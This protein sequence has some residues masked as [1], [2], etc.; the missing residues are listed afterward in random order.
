MSMEECDSAQIGERGDEIVHQLVGTIYDGFDQ[1]W[2]LLENFAEN[3]TSVYRRRIE[4]THEDPRWTLVRPRTSWDFIDFG[5]IDPVPPLFDQDVDKENQIIDDLLNCFLGFHGRYINAESL[6]NP[7]GD[8]IFKI[9]DTVT[10]ICR[11]MAMRLLPLASYYSKIVRF[12]QKGL[13]LSTGRVN[14]ALSGYLEE[15]ILKFSEMIVLLEERHSK[16]PLDLNQL[17]FCLQGTTASMKV[18][19]DVVCAVQDLRG[20]ATLTALHNFCNTCIIDS[21]SKKL[22]VDATLAASEPYFQSI[23]MWIYKGI[24]FDPF[25]EFMVTQKVSVKGPTNW[26]SMFN[27]RV[28]EVPIFLVDCQTYIYK[29]GKYLDAVR[30]SLD[31]MEKMPLLSEE[32]LAY[33]VADE[34][35][36]DIIK[37][38][39]CFASV[40]LLDLMLNRFNLFERIKTTKSFLCLEGGDL[41]HNIIDNCGEELDRPAHEVCVSYLP[42]LVSSSV[43]TSSLGGLKFADQMVL[44]LEKETLRWQVYNL[45]PYGGND[46]ECLEEQTGLEALTFKMEAKWPVSLV[47]H[48]MSIKCYQM[49]FRHLFYLKRIHFKLVRTRQN[50]FLSIRQQYLRHI[51]TVFLQYCISYM[52]IGTIEVHWLD[53]QLA[54]NEAGSVEEVRQAHD[55]M[56]YKCLQGCM[57]ASPKLFHKLRNVLEICSNFADDLCLK[58]ENPFITAVSRLINAALLEGPSAGLENFTKEIAPIFQYEPRIALT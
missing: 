27:I 53:F 33:D 28:S 20:G 8:R 6:E 48:Q 44:Y 2:K 54:F 11:S 37:R 15:K 47:I 43:E 9:C 4:D 57:L 50:K 52:T 24:L 31:D 7:N 16:Y 49:L 30:R 12:A 19:H 35:Y 29:A 56:L 25:D 46:E 34:N 13:E 38:A 40:T 32:P 18:L 3:M 42:L 5:N 41:F 36:V 26:D 58:Q 22:A 23:S 10:G 39:H 17:Y 45:H 51:M 1:E 14:Q 21:H 55:N